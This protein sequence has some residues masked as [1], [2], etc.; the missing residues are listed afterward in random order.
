MKI[1]MGKKYSCDVNYQYDETIRKLYEVEGCEFVSQPEDADVIIFAST[2]SSTEGRIHLIIDYIE[3][4]LNRKKEG[5]KTY[6]TGCLARGFL[7]S[8][9]FSDVTQ[10]LNTH[11]DCVIPNN[12]TNDLL[13]DLLKDQCPEYPSESGA[14]LQV[15]DESADIYISSGCA[16]KCSFCKTTFQKTPL[17]SMDI[18]DVRKYIDMVDAEKIK[19]LYVV[20]MNISQ[21][22]LDKENKYLLPSVIE[23][24]EEKKNIERVCL[25]GLAFSDA[26]RQGFKYTLRDSKKVSLISGSIE[27]G[28]NRV[29]GLMDKGFQIEELLEFYH[30]I[31]QD[32]IKYL[33]T[34]VI[35]GFPTE[36]MEDVE[37]TIRV[38][39]E[40]KPYLDFVGICK[41]MDSSFVRS[42]SLEQLPKETIQEHARVY[43]KF[44]KH[45]GIPFNI[46]R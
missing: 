25:V 4:I 38:L 14:V 18:K 37:A 12:H 1:F 27:S 5:A 31:N 6:L 9:S 23:Y 35:A 44:L 21:F 16:H 40:L 30:F 11:I 2:C 15:D 28:S 42:H 20:G 22:G 10:W 13:K 8:D 24:A 34:S 36:T 39:S 3:S 7:D 32:S 29:L 26:I 17:T 41:Y 19:N 33:T 43:S 46:I 45:E